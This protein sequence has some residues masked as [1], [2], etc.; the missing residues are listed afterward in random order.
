[1]N[2]T[3]DPKKYEKVKTAH[4]ID[5]AKIKDIFLDPYAFEYT[6]EEHSGPDDLRF[7]IVG[8]TSQYGLVHP[9]FT[10]PSEGEIKF[11]TARKAERWLTRVYDKERSRN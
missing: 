5:F 8:V 11:I 7:G 6:D 4:Q 2:Y 1:M 3:W 9:I 10:E